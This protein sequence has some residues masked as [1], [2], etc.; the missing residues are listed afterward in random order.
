M[1]GQLVFRVSYRRREKEGK[2]GRGRRW[3]GGGSGEE[4]EEVEGEWNKDTSPSLPPSLT[5]L[6]V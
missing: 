1:E 2:R 3:E 6:S 5:S 4:G